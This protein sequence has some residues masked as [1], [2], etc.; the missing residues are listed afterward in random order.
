MVGMGG[1]KVLFGIFVRE[2][3]NYLIAL[4]SINIAK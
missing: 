3:E 4:R 1:R 2:G